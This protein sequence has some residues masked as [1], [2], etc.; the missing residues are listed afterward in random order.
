MALGIVGALRRHVALIPQIIGPWHV[1]GVQWDMGASIALAVARRVRVLSPHPGERGL[2]ATREEV[3]L[4]AAENER[5]RIARDLH[6]LLGHSLTTDHCQGRAGRAAGRQRSGAGATRDRRGRGA[7]AARALADVRAAVA[8]YRE[9]RA[10]DRAGDR[11]RG[12]RRRPASTPSCP[13]V[14]DD[15]ARGRR[16]C[17]AGWCAKA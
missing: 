15:V 10:G 14:V 7:R 17:S 2:A 3:A 4:L 6:D 9:V 16:S 5:I 8:G 13:G 11:A 1:K 12:A